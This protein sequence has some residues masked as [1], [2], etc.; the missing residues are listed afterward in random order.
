MSSTG[1]FVVHEELPGGVERGE[2]GGEAEET[3]LAALRGRISPLHSLPPVMPPLPPPPTLPQAARPGAH[4]QTRASSASSLRARSTT[5]EGAASRRQ[6]QAAEEEAAR[7][8][9]EEAMEG[10]DAGVGERLVAAAD[11]CGRPMPLPFLRCADLAPLAMLSPDGTPALDGEEWGE[12][13]G[14]DGDVQAER[15]LADL[16]AGG[17]TARGEEP[18]PLP[19]DVAHTLRAAPPL[20]N[21]ARCAAFRA[22]CAAPGGAA[23]DHLGE[24]AA[25]EAALT[26]A[27]RAILRI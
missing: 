9:S 2:E 8:W 7:A 12:G 16:C 26:D 5:P 24:S 6:G 25:A 21:L 3:L 22:A 10:V 23:R 18:A 19:T 20:L 27:L 13:E 14:E 11:C 17:W 4:G 15:F 1:T